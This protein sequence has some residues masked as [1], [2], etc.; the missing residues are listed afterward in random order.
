[1]K[2]GG[3]EKFTRLIPPSGLGTHCAVRGLVFLQ[4]LFFGLVHGLFTEIQ[5]EI[6]T[7]KEHLGGIQRFQYLRTASRKDGKTLRRIN[8]Q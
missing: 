2:P 7:L 5:P 1:M 8:K 3:K 6:L 4:A